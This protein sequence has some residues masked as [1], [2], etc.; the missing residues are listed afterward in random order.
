[1]ETVEYIIRIEGTAGRYGL[2]EVILPGITLFKAG[3]YNLTHDE[4]KAAILATTVKPATQPE[5]HKRPRR[6]Q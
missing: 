4:L 5:Q 3:R 6:E 2:G 1:M